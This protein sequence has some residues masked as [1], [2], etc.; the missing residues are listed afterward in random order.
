MKGWL[1]KHMPAPMAAPETAE[2]RTARVR[3]IAALV[4]LGAITLSW[5][6]IAGPVALS[7][8]VGLGVF[9]LI[10][11]SFWLRAKNAADDAY[12]MR[13]MSDDE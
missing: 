4:A 12:L 7:M 6:I 1:A 3:L 13:G 2:L 5:N 8:V 10:Q 11:G 9:I